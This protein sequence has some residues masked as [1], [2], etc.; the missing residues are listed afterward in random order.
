MLEK[1]RLPFNRSETMAFILLA[2]I[3]HFVPM[4]GVKV[5]DKRREI[6]DKKN[7]LSAAEREK[8][9]GKLT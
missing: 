2:F 1:D 8:N 4:K 3:V 7:G 9:E 6:A 5:T